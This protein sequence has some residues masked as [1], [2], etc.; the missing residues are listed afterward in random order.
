MTPI[1]NTEN[2]SRNG[3][4][5]RVAFSNASLKQHALNRA[6]KDPGHLYLILLKNSTSSIILQLCLGASLKHALNRADQGH[7]HLYLILLKNSIFWI[8]VQLCLGASL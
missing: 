7:R 2:P 8:T 6:D 1:P 3:I 5:T 4:R